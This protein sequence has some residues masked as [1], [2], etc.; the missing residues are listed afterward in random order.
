MSVRKIVDNG[1]KV[2]FGK[3]SYIEDETTGQRIPLVEKGGMFMLKL[4]VKKDV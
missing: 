2:V 1:N 4:W 3:Q